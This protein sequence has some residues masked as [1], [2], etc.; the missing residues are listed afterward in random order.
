MLPLVFL[1]VWRCRLVSFHIC[2]ASRRS[3]KFCLPVADLHLSSF[4]LPRP[5]STTPDS[6][7]SRSSFSYRAHVF[8]IALTCTFSSCLP[9]YGSPKIGR[10]EAGKIDGSPICL[11]LSPLLRHFLLHLP[12]FLLFARISCVERAPTASRERVRFFSERPTD[13]SLITS[14]LDSCGCLRGAPGRDTRTDVTSRS[15]QASREFQTSALFVIFSSYTHLDTHFRD[16]CVLR[17]MT[18]DAKCHKCL[19]IDRAFSE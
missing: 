17:N 3:S 8:L 1:C 16:N 7:L 19:D 2:K 18:S 15:R 10:K 6:C 4:F 12:S 9:I 13:T 14:G 5:P 11:L